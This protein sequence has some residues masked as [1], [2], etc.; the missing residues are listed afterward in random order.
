MVTG[1]PAD[2]AS[3]ICALTGSTEAAITSKGKRNFLLNASSFRFGTGGECWAGSAESQWLQIR[4]LSTPRV[5]LPNPKGNK[6]FVATISFFCLR[7]TGDAQRPGPIHIM[8][9]QR[10]TKGE[11][12]LN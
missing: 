2:E 6:R 5:G 12:L 7:E 8:G 10:E 1:P 11:A 3:K 9:Q 4:A